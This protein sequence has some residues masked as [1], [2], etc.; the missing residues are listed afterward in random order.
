[1]SV[2]EHWPNRIT[3]LR[4]IGAFVL[5][6]LLSV[7]GEGDP[8]QN[9]GLIQF[10]FWLFVVVVLTDFLDG[11]LARRDNLV[12]TFGR[13]ADP[14][15]DKVLI[16]GVLI[17]LAVLPWS[18][19]WVPAWAV[20]LILARE[21]LVTGIR[22]WLESTGREFGADRLGKIK[23]VLQSIAVGGV[24]FLHAF[25]WPE[26][27]FGYLSWMAHALIWGTIGITL[28]SGAS[29][30]LKARTLTEELHS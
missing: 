17:Y 23:M 8:R 9:I 18:Q 10:A 21:F 28:V 1:V 6:G 13:I 27:L 5:F 16:L 11:Y 19:P 15:V 4:F 3:A 20:V 29:Y 30:V 2:F 26:E 12:S 7:V 25:P 22:G 14:F 24:L